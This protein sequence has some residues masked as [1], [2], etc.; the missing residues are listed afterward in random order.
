MLQTVCPQEGMEQIKT[1]SEGLELSGSRAERNEGAS[2]QLPAACPWAPGPWL[3]QTWAA[4]CPAVGWEGASRGNHVHGDPAV[5]ELT[6]WRGRS[7][8]GKSLG[9]T[10]GAC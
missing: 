2:Q 10:T 7:E 1:P 3:W 4:W 9:Q 8:G 5:G 6:V